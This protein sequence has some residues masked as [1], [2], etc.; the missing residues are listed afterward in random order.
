MKMIYQEQPAGDADLARLLHD[1]M[2][3]GQ[4]T[5]AEVMAKVEHRFYYDPKFAAM[6][7]MVVGVMDMHHRLDPGETDVARMAA[8]VAFVVTEQH[9]EQRDRELLARHL[10]ALA[11]A[12]NVEDWPGYIRDVADG[13]DAG[14]SWYRP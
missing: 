11:S 4:A 14:T 8:A 5:S 2:R 3:H 1:A 12:E 6:V 7:K 13:H 10:R 9:Q